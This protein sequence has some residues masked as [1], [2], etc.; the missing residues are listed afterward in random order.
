MTLQSSGVI[1]IS[2]INVE[3]GRASN[4]HTSLNESACRILANV[5]SGTIRLSNFYGKTK[6]NAQWSGSS[7]ANG[8]TLGTSGGLFRL[9]GGAWLT[10]YLDG[11]F[12]SGYSY[13]GDSAN[14]ILQASGNAWR[15]SQG[16]GVA[17]GNGGAWATVWA[18]FSISAKWT[19]YSNALW[20]LNG[21][22]Y[23]LALQ[24]SSGQIRLVQ[25]V[26]NSIYY[27][28]AYISLS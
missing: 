24:A 21:Y 26:L 23:E 12:Q 11:T 17:G 4:A 10:T 27:Y 19:N 1:R 5:P 13:A 7:T 16:T 2:N 9:G 15:V 3:L 25:R 28:G 18:Y 20:I 14:S 22:Y 8:L 6:F